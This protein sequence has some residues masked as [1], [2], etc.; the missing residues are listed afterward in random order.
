MLS[1]NWSSQLKKLPLC[2]SLDHKFERQSL[3]AMCSFVTQFPK[4]IPMS[5]QELKE[6]CYALSKCQCCEKHM[7]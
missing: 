5:Y 2:H 6:Y 4:E 1:A 3:E 7:K